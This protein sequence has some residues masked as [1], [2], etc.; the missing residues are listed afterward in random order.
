MKTK[1]QHFKENIL[2][3]IFSDFSYYFMVVFVFYFIEMNILCELFIIFYLFIDRILSTADKW[4]A[5]YQISEIE[6][7]IKSL[8]DNSI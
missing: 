1:Q 6:K 8:K 7:K 3:I 4:Y 2:P 5:D